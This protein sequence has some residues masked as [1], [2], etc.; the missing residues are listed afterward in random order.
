MA[1]RPKK[2]SG[3]PAMP[4]G[5]NGRYGLLSSMP[6]EVT[7]VREKSRTFCYAI[8]LW[9]SRLLDDASGLGQ[10][11][12]SDDK[13]AKTSPTPKNGSPSK[14]KDALDVSPSK[15]EHGK[16]AADLSANY[17]RGEGQKPVSKAYKDNWNAI[18][19]KKKKR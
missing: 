8:K 12:A 7:K 16:K 14:N 3:A 18:F 6:T 9:Q 4:G 5:G 17:S 2:E 10:T 15:A 11:M 19:A 1:E 13:K